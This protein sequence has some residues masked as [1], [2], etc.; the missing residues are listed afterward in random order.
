[1]IKQRTVDEQV[2]KMLNLEG[3]KFAALPPSLVLRER[4]R[5]LADFAI[6]NESLTRSEFYYYGELEQFIFDPLLRLAKSI[7]DP[8]GLRNWKAGTVED[9]FVRMSRKYALLAEVLGA[10]MSSKAM[11]NA[12]ADMV[13]AMLPV[14]QLVRSQGQSPTQAGQPEA[15][16]QGVNRT[17][18]LSQAIEM[19]E[20]SNFSQQISPWKYKLMN[21]L[22]AKEGAD[23]LNSMMVLAGTGSGQPLPFSHRYEAIYRRTQVEHAIKILAN[24]SLHPHYSASSSTSPFYAD[25]YMMGVIYLAYCY[26]ASSQAAYD[27]IFP[28]MQMGVP[29]PARL[30]AMY[31]SARTISSFAAGIS[32]AGQVS[33][34]YLAGKLLDAAVEFM[35]P[36][37]A[38]YTHDILDFDAHRKAA[39][40][41]LQK[42]TFTPIF[43]HTDKVLELLKKAAGVD[44]L[45]PQFLVKYLNLKFPELKTSIDVSPDMLHLAY[46]DISTVEVPSQVIPDFFSRVTTLA[47]SIRGTIDELANALLISALS[48]Q[49]VDIHS[50]QLPADFMETV[51]GVQPSLQDDMFHSLTDRAFIPLTY[52]KYEREYG[53]V[54][55]GH[56]SDEVLIP[57]PV[58]GAFIRKTEPKHILRDWAHKFINLNVFRRR[59]VEDN[60]HFY[61]DPRIQLPL[62]AHLSKYFSSLP[63]PYPLVRDV[64]YSTLPATWTSV[65]KMVSSP[66]TPGA[67]RNTFLLDAA[68]MLSSETREKHQVLN[69]LAGLAVVYD[70]KKK[71]WMNPTFPAIYGVP[72]TLWVAVQTNGVIPSSTIWDKLVKNDRLRTVTWTNPLNGASHTYSFLLISYVPR[73]DNLILLSDVISQ[74]AVAPVPVLAPFVDHV[75]FNSEELNLTEADEERDVFSF[76]W[77]ALSKVDATAANFVK[78]EFVDT[79]SMVRINYPHLRIRYSVNYSKWADDQINSM[80]NFKIYRAVG[81]YPGTFSV[82]VRDDVNVVLFDW[83]DY[84]VL[85]ADEILGADLALGELSSHGSAWGVPPS[86]SPVTPAGLPEPT[87]LTSQRVSMSNPLPQHDAHKFVTTPVDTYVVHGTDRKLPYQ[88]QDHQKLTADDKQALGISKDPAIG[89]IERGESAYHPDQE[90]ERPDIAESS[91]TTPMDDVKDDASSEQVDTTAEDTSSSEG[92][93]SEKDKKKKKRKDSGSAE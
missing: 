24:P 32:L 75:S 46:V 14:F 89:D 72:T 91:D 7:L 82:V 41:A 42:F 84:S 20:N 81:P 40:E 83:E 27:S 31:R 2:L 8:N 54:K 76:A 48:D 86:S 79:L 4:T 45:I 92:Q 47:L 38:A 1:M 19:L 78:W 3:T 62:G 33:E 25:A 59:K 36:A 71:K 18:Y 56:T 21:E 44:Q 28:P 60:G 57:A 6:T 65:F 5:H 10:S 93:D 77:R 67:S 23:L 88:P 53:Y 64:V 66:L 87:D 22:Q 50:L 49:P 55:K 37:I 52:A 34:V 26:F 80:L 63:L 73:P 70:H 15:P 61:F 17:T 39:N 29:A 16:N 13:Q 58:G 51:M 30:A 12:T 90:N 74:G 68:I 35:R 43:S 85:D 9:L 69:A 11:L